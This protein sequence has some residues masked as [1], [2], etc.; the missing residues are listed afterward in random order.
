MNDIKLIFLNMLAAVLSFLS[1]I[2][3]FMVAAMVLF[4]MNFVCGLLAGIIGGE[5]WSWRKAFMCF[6]HGFIFFGFATFIYMCG[7]FMHNNVG[8]VQLVSLMCY[9]ALYI[10]GV[11]I[12]R[13]MRFLAKDD[14]PLYKLLDFMYYV[15]TFEFCK[16]LPYWEGYVKSKQE[17]ELKEFKGREFG[18]N[19]GCQE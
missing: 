12:L 6:V 5:G 17:Q 8:A 7:Y 1:P 14:T 15:L 18:G 3:D 4:T 9:A 11:N 13:N 10:Y 2:T 19:R 16:K